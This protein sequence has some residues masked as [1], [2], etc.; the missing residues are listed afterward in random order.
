MYWVIFSS[1]S[2]PI[3]WLRWWKSKTGTL[4]SW[5]LITIP[6]QKGKVSNNVSVELNG[7]LRKTTEDQPRHL[8]T[9]PWRR[10]CMVLSLWMKSI[11]N[12]QYFVPI[13]WLMFETLLTRGPKP[14]SNSKS[15]NV[16]LYD[17]LTHVVHELSIQM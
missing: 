3:T 15:I 1:F 17:V 2:R 7:C 4:W 13:F 14:V 11:F 8:N 10:L 9:S 6:S 5:E 16:G 12:F